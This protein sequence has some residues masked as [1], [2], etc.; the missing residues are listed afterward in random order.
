MNVKQF[1]KDNI[2]QSLQDQGTC[3]LITRIPYT[4]YTYIIN[5]RFIDTNTTEFAFI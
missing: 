1:S 3:L 2:M 4:T 5:K